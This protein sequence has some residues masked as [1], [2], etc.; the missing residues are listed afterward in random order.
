[1]P[2]GDAAVGAPARPDIIIGDKAHLPAGCH[3]VEVIEIGSR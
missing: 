2:P 3:G 1:M